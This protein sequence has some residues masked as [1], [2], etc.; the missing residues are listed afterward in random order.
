MDD[1][2]QKEETGESSSSNAEIPAETKQVD[3]S[4]LQGFSIGPTWGDPNYTESS[5]QHVETR[6]TRD[7]RPPSKGRSSFR[8]RERP[9]RRPTRPE[10]SRGDTKFGRRHELKAPFKPVVGVNFYPEDAPFR[11]LCQAMRQSCR[12]YE[13]FELT[14]LILEKPERLVVALSPLAGT[15]EGL[16]QFYISVPDNLPFESE[17]EAVTHLRN[18]HADMFFQLESVEVEPPRGVF[19]S[20]NRCSITGELLGPPNFH[21]YSQIEQTHHATRLAKMSLEKFRS[22]IESLTDPE[23]I[24]EWLQKM[25]H[26]TRYIFKGKQGD[27][28]EPHTFETPESAWRFLLSHHREKAI[29]VSATVRFSG[30]LLGNLSSRGG[31]RLSVETA[32][33][34]QRRFPLDT[35][36]H[37]RG[38]LRRLHFAVYKKGTKGVSFVCAAKRQFRSPDDNFAEPVM[39]LIEF[40]EK[41]PSIHVSKLPEEFLGIT[42]EKKEAGSPAATEDAAGETEEK[43]VKKA[44]AGKKDTKTKKTSAKKIAEDKA[45]FNELGQNLHWLITEGYVVEYSDGKLF[46]PPTRTLSKGGRKKDSRPVADKAHPPEELVEV[47]QEDPATPTDDSVPLPVETEKEETSDLTPEAEP[48]IPAEP[49]SKEEAAVDLEGSSTDQELP[50]SDSI[51]ENL[52]DAPPPL[53]EP[54]DE[55][56]PLEPNTEPETK[57]EGENKEGNVEDELEGSDISP[58]PTEA[59]IKD[60]PAEENIEAEEKQAS[61]PSIAIGGET[62]F[63]LIEPLD[64]SQTEISP[65]EPDTETDTKRET[66]NKEGAAE[67][68]V[69]EADE[70]STSESGS[71]ASPE[72]PEALKED[73]SSEEILD[74]TGNSPTS[75]NPPKTDNLDS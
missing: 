37:L 18:S 64:E 55:T 65:P 44:V 10:G 56:A 69:K 35:A 59:S 29:H 1:E 16:K 23:T 17:E 7:R 33:D 70:L 13:L 57:K 20:V 5:K 26:Q 41:H 66:E 21:R 53:V 51:V 12:T 52:E 74:T 6:T 46:A 67:N 73:S 47:T 58:E 72:T 19:K 49:V 34:A 4:D 32:L 39:E 60:L 8:A 61:A 71:D 24:D 22:K 3:L 68:E 36:N 2:K 15:D 40:I 43:T 62:P 75:K 42:I 11:A 28:G 30:K 25:K 48:E 38:R 27:E 50:V 63:P 9:D 31:I 45:R 54:L 14:R